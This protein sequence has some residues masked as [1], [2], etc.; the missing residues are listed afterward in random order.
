MHLVI[1]KLRVFSFTKGTNKKLSAAKQFKKVLGRENSDPISSLQNTA[2]L[3]TK[4]FFIRIALIPLTCLPLLLSSLLLE[5]QIYFKIYVQLPS[6]DR[7]NVKSCLA[8]AELTGFLT[9]LSVLS[10][11]EQIVHF[12][13]FQHYY[14]PLC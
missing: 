8:K 4:C 11:P 10:F 12:E 13:P 3:L 9:I 1:S 5:A 14:V 6:Y 2:L 7:N